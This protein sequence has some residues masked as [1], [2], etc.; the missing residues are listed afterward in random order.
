MGV[1]DIE[2]KILSN[3]AFLDLDGTLIELVNSDHKSARLPS[4]VTMVQGSGELVKLLKLSGYLPVIVTNQPDVSRGL[5]HQEDLELAHRKVMNSLEISHKYACYHDDL[6][7]CPCRKPQSGL[8]KMAAED[9]HAKLENSI[10]I[11]DSWRDIAAAND[12]S[13]FS[14]YISNEGKDDLPIGCKPNLRKTS[15]SQL[16]ENPGEIPNVTKN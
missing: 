16:L 14:I 8:L 9:L 2:S 15:L 11:G 1:T 12:V 7:L 6:D 13:V 5:V 4:E 10:L 3:I